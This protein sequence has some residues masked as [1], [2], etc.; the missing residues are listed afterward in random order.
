MNKLYVFICIC[1][2]V[3]GLAQEITVD[4]VPP[5]V[6]SLVIGNDQKLGKDIQKFSEKDNLL[7]KLLG[8]IVKKDSGKE[9][10]GLNYS[11][12]HYDR[13]DGKIIKEIKIVNLN[14]FS[15]SVDQDPEE[16]PW[17]ARTGNKL[18]ITTQPWVVR[19][20]LLF[21]AG[22]ELNP[23]FISESE[24]ILRTKP[25]LHSADIQ[26]LDEEENS[27][28]ITVQVVVRDVWSILPDARYSLSDKKGFL[29][30]EDVNFLGYGMTFH[31]ALKRGL[32]YGNEWTVDAGLQI[33]H[34]F[35]QY[36]NARI[37]RESSDHGITYG[38]GAGRDFI[39]PV[40]KL[41]GGFEL[42]RSENLIRE[43]ENENINLHLEKLFV[44]DY[45]IG[46][47]TDLSRITHTDKFQNEYYLAA[48][49]KNTHFL[50]L[51]EIKNDFY[52]NNR[53]ALVSLGYAFR[54][55][56]KTRFVRHL[57]ITE[58]IPTGT[59]VSFTFGKRYSEHE[60]RW[61]TGVKAGYGLFSKI[62]YF[63]AVIESG[64]YFKK[65]DN[66][67]G[68]I[69]AALLYFTPLHRFGG[70]TIRNFFRLRG[71]YLHNPFLFDHMVNLDHSNDIRGFNAER[72]GNKRFTVNYEFNI[73]P[74]VKI[75]GFNFA[76]IGFTDL[77]WLLPDHVKSWSSQF[78]QGFGGGLRIK[79]EM[80]VFRSIQILF[81][82]YPNG[83]D[84]KTRFFEQPRDFYR[85]EDIEFTKPHAVIE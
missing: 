28:S 14:V 57:G 19:N 4:T 59:T 5:S 3:W 11:Y 31:T 17:L 49:Y 43:I 53:L 9:V 8:N 60:D 1:I 50:K 48:G 66:E 67:L 71:S 47:A 21:K 34:L 7:S 40:L 69:D 30:F 78:Y 24:R 18:H 68:A 80:L 61:Y 20:Q 10:N 32:E 56:H 38:V 35:Y 73:Y 81:G 22:E 79:N 36:V 75:F 64:T 29:S 74:P 62:G 77:T 55:Y 63:S 85:L 12:E 84:Y 70:T 25:Y 13:H 26:I 6:D 39:S 16:L 27:D 76:V 45:W 65:K 41:A 42:Q 33:D 54:R 2:P 52:G 44:Q 72:I 15:N 23:F 83:T 58:D 82:Y 51:P 37:Y 46:Y